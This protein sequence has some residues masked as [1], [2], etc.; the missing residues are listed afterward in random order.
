[1]K[2]YRTRDIVRDIGYYR[3][4][5]VWWYIFQYILMMDRYG[6]SLHEG[7]IFSED[8]GHRILTHEPTIEDLDHI[9]VE[10]DEIESRGMMS[11]DI[12]GERTISRS[13]LDD[14]ATC[15]IE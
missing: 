2:Q 13:Y 10:L 12:L 3:V 6:S 14:M 5:V 11:E 9:W 7:I 4:V 15:D 8:L 1:M